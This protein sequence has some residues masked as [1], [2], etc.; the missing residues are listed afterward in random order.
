VDF[1]VLNKRKCEEADMEKWYART[2][3][4]K[5]CLMGHKVRQIISLTLCVMV[6]IIPNRDSNGI[7]EGKQ[8]LTAM[9]GTNSKIL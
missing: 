5:E 8:T 6:N 1:A 9:S 7:G 3:K 4:G 2:A